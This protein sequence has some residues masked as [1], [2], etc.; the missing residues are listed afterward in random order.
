MRADRVWMHNR[1]H[2]SRIGQ[3]DEFVAGVDQFIGY[4][5]NNKGFVPDYYQWI[6][7]GE[8]FLHHDDIERVGI[9]NDAR[10]DV[11]NFER[12][13]DVEV[14]EPNPYRTMI[15]VAAGPGSLKN[16]FVSNFLKQQMRRQKL[17][18]PVN[19]PNGSKNMFLHQRTR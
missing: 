12:V 19:S 4:V 6:W 8:P 17:Q 1:R 10:D 7:H 13:V 14:D 18:P 2:H 3:N 16:N 5:L 15:P 9:E 11:D